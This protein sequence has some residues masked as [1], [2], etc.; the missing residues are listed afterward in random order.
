MEW[1]AVYRRQTQ[2]QPFCCIKIGP[3]R[4]NSAVQVP[5][6]YAPTNDFLSKTRERAARRYGR[7]DNFV[8]ER[9]DEAIAP[10][11]QIGGVS[12][13]VGIDLF[14]SVDAEGIAQLSANLGGSLTYFGLLGTLLGIFY[15]VSET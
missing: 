1:M 6:R 14:A 13:A 10:T 2:R 3:L 4:S 8:C 15:A 7:E 5:C 11:G 12:R 9:A